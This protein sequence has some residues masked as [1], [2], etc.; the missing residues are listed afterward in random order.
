MLRPEEPYLS[1][2]WLEAT[3]VT[4]V[5]LQLRVVRE[6]LLAKG[7]KLPAK[8][9]LAVL[10][11]EAS[12]RLVQ[13]ETSDS[14]RLSAHSEKLPDDPSHAGIYG[15]SQEDDLIADLLAISILGQH[16]ARG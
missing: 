13:A 2:N 5:D 3:G 15:Y 11:I 12:F 7:M 4:E 6:H 8:G 16:P 14:R 10:H 1:V 9:S